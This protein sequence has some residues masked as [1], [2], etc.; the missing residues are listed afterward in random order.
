MQASG[1]VK[2]YNTDMAKKM[3]AQKSIIKSFQHD[4][5]LSFTIGVSFVF[6]LQLI[7]LKVF[8]FDGMKYMM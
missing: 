1:E 2:L 3:I 5:R 6:V 8:I 7:Y 4:R